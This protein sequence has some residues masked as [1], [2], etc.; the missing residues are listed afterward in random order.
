MEATPIV[1]SRTDPTEVT[2]GQR[3]GVAWRELRRGASMIRFRELLYGP[4]IEIGQEVI[5][6]LTHKLVVELELI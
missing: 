5:F 2:D 6:K 1:R 3:I 4:D